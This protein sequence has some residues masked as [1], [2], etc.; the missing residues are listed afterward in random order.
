[1]HIVELKMQNGFSNSNILVDLNEIY[2]AHDATEDGNVFVKFKNGDGF[3]LDMTLDEY[4]KAIEYKP[5]AKVSKKRNFN[6]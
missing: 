1:M 6:L 2:Y 5:N 4:R 3:M